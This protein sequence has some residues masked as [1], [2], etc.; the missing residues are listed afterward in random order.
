MNNRL[1]KR[2]WYALPLPVIVWLR[3][4]DMA[5]DWDSPFKC[6]VHDDLRA[7]PRSCWEKSDQPTCLKGPQN[8]KT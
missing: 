7:C 8:V 1:R 2:L 4:R 5:P 6:S 3:Q